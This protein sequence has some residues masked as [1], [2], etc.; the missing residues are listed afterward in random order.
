M[1]SGTN[2]KQGR[3]DPEARGAYMHFY[4]IAQRWMDSDVY[5]HMNNVVYYSFFDTAVNRYLVERGALDI[6]KST[7][8]GLVVETQCRFFS[9]ITFP[10]MVNVGMRVD[11]IGTS[12]LRYAIALFSDEAEMASA[13]G[14][15]VHV[16]VDRA[17]NRPVPIPNAVR[18]AIVP[19]L[20]PRPDDV[21]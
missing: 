17:T 14:H 21:K 7:E 18:T 1:N 13:Q 16:Y 15:F 9:P 8:I 4:A 3:P 10:S 5:R 12:S 20:R 6:E 19:L 2:A 11:H